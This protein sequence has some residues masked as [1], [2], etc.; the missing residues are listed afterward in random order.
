MTNFDSDVF[1]FNVKIFLA[2]KAFGKQFNKNIIE[3]IAKQE[4]GHG[5]GTCKF[6]RIANVSFSISIYLTRLQTVKEKPLKK[7]MIGN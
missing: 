3:F 6:Q 7:P 1:I 2:E 5:S 4:F